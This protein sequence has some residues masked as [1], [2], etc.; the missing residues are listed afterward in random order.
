MYI[1]SSYGYVAKQLPHPHVAT[2]L[3][4]IADEGDSSCDATDHDFVV[5]LNIGGRHQTT[6]DTN[7]MQLEG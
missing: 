5:V 3:T 2:P 1:L 4:I 6:Q 7:S